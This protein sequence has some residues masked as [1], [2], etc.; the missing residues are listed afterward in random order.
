MHEDNITPGNREFVAE[1]ASDRFG[2][3]VLLKNVQ[4]DVKPFEFTPRLRR[5][6]LLA[7]KIGHDI[8]W[9]TNGE[10]I[11]TTMLHVETNYVIR[12][13]PPDKVHETP[14]RV[15]KPSR[16]GIVLIGTREADPFHFTKEYCGLFKD[17]GVTPK[18]HLGRFFVSPEARLT[19]GNTLDVTHF[20]VG[21]FVDASAFT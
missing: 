20:R 15:N 19:A 9:R 6:G 7:E 3:P 2:V 12:Y 8:M 10:K 13:T 4:E 21:D 1:A 16:H 11:I 14:Q 18:R 17:S 5:C